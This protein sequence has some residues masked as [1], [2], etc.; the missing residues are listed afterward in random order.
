MHEFA[1]N[2]SPVVRVEDAAAAVR[3]DANHFGAGFVDALPELRNLESWYTKLGVHTR[4]L[5]VFMMPTALAGVDSHE[6][7]AAAE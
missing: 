7:L 5:Y 3:M 2:G 6:E 1:G 4:S